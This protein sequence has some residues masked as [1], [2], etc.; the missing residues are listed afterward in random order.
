MAQPFMFM[1]KIIII[2]ISFVTFV[3]LSVQLSGTTLSPM[4]EFSRNATF[5]YFSKICR[6]ELVSLKSYKSDGCLG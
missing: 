6:K 1:M 3:C 2:I 5:E 4:D